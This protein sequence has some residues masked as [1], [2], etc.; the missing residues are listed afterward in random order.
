MKL[1]VR[2]QDN[3]VQVDLDGVAGR[4]QHVLLALSECQRRACTGQ[5]RPSTPEDVCI[6]AGADRM[7]IRLKGSDGLRYE[8]AAIYQCLREV[9]VERTAIAS[10]PAP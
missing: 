7:R 2:E 1:R 4:Q 9:L 6:R 8:A 3:E 10:P 5:L